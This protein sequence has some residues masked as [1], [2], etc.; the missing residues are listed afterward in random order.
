[1]GFS[2]SHA[3]FGFGM[4]F[5]VIA[6]I[7]A[8]NL[9]WPPLIICAIVPII[10]GGAY[11]L[12]KL[13]LIECVFLIHS[14]IAGIFYFHIYLA[15]RAK[16]V[17]MPFE[18]KVAFSAIVS[19]EPEPVAHSVILNANLQMPL[20]GSVEI[21]APPESDFHYGD[22][23]TVNGK[24]EPSDAPGSNPFVLPTAVTFISAHHGF[25]LRE[26]M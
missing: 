1:M 23:I 20:K 12:Q 15:W 24:I 17:S 5:A 18:E 11:A 13:T 21:L 3:D 19:D 8:A 9:G 4:A 16:G 14:L 22:L 7:F 10:L 6:G 25:W 2:L 26:A